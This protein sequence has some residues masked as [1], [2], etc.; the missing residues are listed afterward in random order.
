MGYLDDKY[1]RE[2]IVRIGSQSG[3]YDQLTTTGITS[4]DQIIN[5]Y[6]LLDQSTY[7]QSR[8]EKM[9]YQSDLARLLEIQKQQEA[10]YEEWYN[11]SEQAAIREREAG[12]NP[13]LAGLDNAGSA[14]QVAPSELVP[15]A[16]LPTNGEVASNV[17]SGITSVIGS[18]SSVASLATAFTTLPLTLEQTKNAKKV[19]EHLDLQNEAQL[20]TM[21]ASDI[22]DL[23]ATAQ[24]AHIDSGSQDPFD[25]DGFFAND[26][27][28][29]TLD[30]IYGSNPR[31]ASQLA[32][33]RKA[34]LA[35]QKRAAE[36]QSGFASAN[37]SLANIIS[38]PR[39][40]G[41]QKLTMIQLR[42]FVEACVNADAAEVAL[43]DSIASWSKLRQDGMDVN[44]A[45][46]AAN[47]ANRAS[48]SQSGYT[49][50]YYDEVDGKL[51]AAYEQFFRDSMM[52]SLS[53]QQSI[54][55]GYLDLFNSDP[56]GEAGY[57]AAYLFGSNGGSSWEEVYILRQKDSI[58][59]LVDS[60][61][62]VAQA[63]GDYA[64]LQAM[65]NAF[66]NVFSLG[67]DYTSWQKNSAGWAMYRHEVKEYI[68][69]IQRI[70]E[71]VN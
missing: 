4:R 34:V 23:L 47:S 7:G 17:I 3:L 30:P 10:S 67:T 38:D 13:D 25:I 21:I 31:Y 14:S 35:H 28:F 26:S 60:K 12:I 43:R 45:I 63:T 61:I 70:L 9:R 54:N 18:L 33:Q 46:D 29:A 6:E 52:P 15:G 56:S 5:P 20:G 1:M 48:I 53:L 62:A 39:Y 58:K 40:T 8:R 71:D 11:S 19:G 27:N 55:Q 51:V 59:K 42:P 57:K 2:E 44:L 50:A 66:N 41:D 36:S 65:M 49:E 64:E 37:W 32:K 69:N 22:S 24:Q 68:D 16:N